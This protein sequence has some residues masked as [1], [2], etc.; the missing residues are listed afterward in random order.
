MYNVKSKIAEEFISDSEIRDTMQ[1]A[2]ENKDNRELIMSI[3]E[4]ARAYKGISH[5]E[6]ALLL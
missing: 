2:A 6:A 5:R 3:L 1:Y 4:K